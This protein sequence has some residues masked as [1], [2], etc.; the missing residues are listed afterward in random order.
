MPGRSSAARAED[1]WNNCRPW[2]RQFDFLP[3]GWFVVGPPETQGFR[4]ESAR[5]FLLFGRPLE[6]SRY[7]SPGLPVRKV[8]VIVKGYGNATVRTRNGYYATPAPPPKPKRAASSL[9]KPNI[10]QQ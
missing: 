6:Y 7:S 5:Y 3:R 1:V 2:R 4:N 10:E 8:N 9:V